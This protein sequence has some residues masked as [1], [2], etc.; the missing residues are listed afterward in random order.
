MKKLVIMRG[1]P[2]SGKSTEARKLAADYVYRKGGSAAICSTDDFH[3][4]NGK[5]VFKRDL[6]G[7]FHARNQTRVYDLMKMGIELVVVDNT[8][9][10]RRD[11]QPYIDSAGRLGYE[12]EELIVGK[13]QLCP[14]FDE[15][16]QYKL[17]DYIDECTKRNTHG[18]PRDAIE[19]MARRF[20]K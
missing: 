13:D 12:V 7:E 16:C 6:L 15:A 9:I 20:E 10:K 17:A 11:M 5:Y 14:A 4:E 18:V 2:G 3:M 19:K 1:L 8:N